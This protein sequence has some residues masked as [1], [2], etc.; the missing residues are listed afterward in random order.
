VDAL[1]AIV[2]ALAAVGLV[3]AVLTSYLK[4]N[5]IW[6]RKH[7]PD[8][9]DSVSVTAAMLSL[10]VTVPFLLKFILIE[11]DYIAASKYVV[12]LFVFVVFFLIG[13]GAWVEREPRRGFWRR[14]LDAL[15]TERSELTFFLRSITRP[16]EAASALRLLR[17]VAWVDGHLDWREQEIIETVARQNGLLTKE[18]CQIPPEERSNVSAARRGLLDYLALKPHPDQVRK[19]W[20]LVRFMASADGL[21]S[22]RERVILDE[23]HLL[24]RQYLDEAHTPA[25]RF[26]VLVVP[27]HSTQREEI[28]RLLGEVDP[29]PRAGGIAFLAVTTFTERFALE[30]RQRYRRLGYFCTVE[31]APALG[32]APVFATAPR[33]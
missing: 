11:Q 27:Q 26:E 13:I 19:M 14:L 15:H 7:I 6:A 2:E 3:I 18:I 17:S 32:V 20:R 8:V 5:K 31:E 22:L 23:L 33:G 4:V 1:P 28:R 10:L 30:V 29:V 25:P 16:R 21:V 9:A 24:V 12:S